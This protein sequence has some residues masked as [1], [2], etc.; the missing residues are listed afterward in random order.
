MKK[1]VLNIIN[2]DRLYWIIGGIFSLYF[3]GHLFKALINANL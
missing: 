3:L 2:D 1:T